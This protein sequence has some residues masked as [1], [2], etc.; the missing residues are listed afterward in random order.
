[1]TIFW[2]MNKS[3][4]LLGL[5]WWILAPIT[6]L[7]ILFVGLFLISAGLDELANPAAARDADTDHGT[8]GSRPDG[9]LPHRRRLVR[10]VDRASFDVAPARSSAWSANPVP[11]RARW[12]S[13]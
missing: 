4:F 1:M 11:A 10:A 3:A 13:P 6:V 7:I 5:W 2:L 8:P 9:E 12:R